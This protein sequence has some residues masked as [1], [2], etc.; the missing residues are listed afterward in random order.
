[1]EVDAPHAAAHG[2]AEHAH[3]AP[4]AAAMVF[5]DAPSAPPAGGGAGVDDVTGGGD[6]EDVVDDDDDE[7]AGG[8]GGAALPPPADASLA[9]FPP[10]PNPFP[11]GTVKWWSYNALLDA[12]P[13]GR[14][15]ED[16]IARC[17]KLGHDWNGSRTPSN[18][19]VSGLSCDALF[20]RTGPKRYAIAAVVY[21]GGAPPP[22][23]GP[24][25]GRG[26]GRGAAAAARPAVREAGAVPAAA[27]RA[28][29][30][31]GGEAARPR[32]AAAARAEAG[33]VAMLQ[34]DDGRRA[35]TAT[36]PLLGAPASLAS[37]GAGVSSGFFGSGGFAGFGGG[38]VSMPP[39]PRRRA[40]TMADTPGAWCPFAPLPGGRQV[41][42]PPPEGV[43]KKF[44]QHRAEALAAAAA[45]AGLP[46]PRPLAPEPKGPHPCFVLRGDA[47][48]F[49]RVAPGEGSG[50]GDSATADGLLITAP[51]VA[52]SREHAAAA[53]RCRVWLEQGRLRVR[54]G[55]TPAACVLN[56]VPLDAFAAATLTPGCSLSL[57]AMDFPKAERG[58]A[59]PPRQTVV[60]RPAAPRPTFVSFGASPPLQPPARLFQS[61]LQP[62]QLPERRGPGRP[63][64]PGRGRGR[65][66]GPGR[67]RGRPPGASY[68]AAYAGRD[69]QPA[70]AMATPMAF[71]APEPQHDEEEEE[72]GAE[73]EDEEASDE[74]PPPVDAAMEN[75]AAG[76]DGDYAEEEDEMED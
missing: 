40:L 43:P 76:G 6:D 52:L 66:P 13:A 15:A 60:V 62:Q 65:P 32:R 54:A 2:A 8:D 44:Y 14:R 64:G 27:A 17:V 21:R 24:V 58:A 10:P 39:A 57:S 34:A 33:I 53:K 35:V 28:G 18:S 59:L 12:G 70:P 22:G 56:G 20:A 1:M 29:F 23:V 45:A 42:R 5:A 4:A 36:P 30:S 73:D 48:G 67:G 19:V 51:G 47:R 68:S 46:P 16:I 75:D 41:L 69:T 7:D 50:L 61:P 71:K 55:R 25:G 11:K 74:E 63:P 49:E 9:H 72:G 26:R 31:P 37:P 38:P 3:A